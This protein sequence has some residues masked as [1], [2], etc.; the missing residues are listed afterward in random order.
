MLPGGV[1]HLDTE[2]TACNHYALCIPPCLSLHGLI[3]LHKLVGFTTLSES[4]NCR[5]L[6]RT[7]QLVSKTLANDLPMSFTDVLT[8]CLDSVFLGRWNSVSEQRDHG[9]VQISRP[10]CTTELNKRNVTL[11]QSRERFRLV[12][13]NLIVG[14]SGTVRHERSQPRARGTTGVKIGVF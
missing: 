11:H 12:F 8:F 9:T 14:A 3:T 4:P 5:V 6:A 2:T 13:K 10:W 7:P 1:P